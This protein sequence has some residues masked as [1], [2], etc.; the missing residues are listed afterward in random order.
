MFHLFSQVTVEAP[1]E[2]PFF[3]FGQGWS[4]V[5]PERSVVSYGLVCHPL[6]VGDVCV[7]LT[8]KE[9]G[10]PPGVKTERAV[11][12][13]FPVT[14]EI[15]IREIPVREPEHKRIKT[16]LNVRFSPHSHQHGKL[17]PSTQTMYHKRTAEGASHSSHVSSSGDY[18]HS[19]HHHLG[20]PPV[21][22]SSMGGASTGQYSESYHKLTERFD[23]DK[24]ANTVV[25]R[26]NVL[27]PP[28]VATSDDRKSTVAA[29]S[30]QQIARPLKRRWS[31]PVKVAE[32]SAAAAHQ[33][34]L[35]LPAPVHPEMLMKQSE[36]H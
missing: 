22:R 11:V 33:K 1:M 31:D 27:S 30:E 20:H 9:N 28:A 18:P 14:R 36:S 35:T 7:S 10:R 19:S 15:P 23:V 26:T 6:A 21:Q 2:H 32:S 25:V 13:T 24:N 5:Q 17:A 12:E 4:A 16:E 34:D 3:V 29:V 8:V